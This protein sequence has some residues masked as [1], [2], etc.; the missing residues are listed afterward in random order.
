M[1]NDTGVGHLSLGVVDY[2][3][4]LKVGCVEPF[5]LKAQT[6]VVEV[7]VAVIVKLIDAAGVECAAGLRM[8]FVT[9][10][11][12][13]GAQAYIGL[14][15]QGVD[16]CIVSPTLGYALVAVVEIVVVEGEAEGQPLDDESRQLGGGTAPL[17]FGIP[18][19]ESLVNVAP[20]Q[21]ECLLLKVGGLCDVGNSLRCSSILARASAGVRTPHSS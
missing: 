10:G 7:A 6:A 5:V 16:E 17:L 8:E 1:L 14:G 20:A 4:A 12:V 13:V 19:D 18:L 2:G 21:C 11:K 15:Q 9:V 3:I